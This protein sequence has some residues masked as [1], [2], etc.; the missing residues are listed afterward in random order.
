MIV[1]KEKD[2]VYFASPMKYQDYCTQARIDYTFEENGHIWHLNDEYSTIVMVDADNKRLTDVLRYSNVF[3]CEFSKDGMNQ[4]IANIKKFIKGT[5]CFV[6][7]GKL[8]FSLC[9]ARGN[10]AYRVTNY[11]A[12]FETAEIECFNESEERMLAAYE[13]CK[14]IP[15][16]QKRI[17]TLYNQVGELSNRQYYPIAVINTKDKSYSL[18]TNK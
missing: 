7:D 11:G 4:I 16:V 8:G 15:D 13:Y 14:N 17:E 9:V 6:A 10:K 5:N 12:V 3:D 18:L 1:I 2:A